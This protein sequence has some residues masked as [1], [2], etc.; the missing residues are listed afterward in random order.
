MRSDFRLTCSLPEIHGPGSV[1]RLVR[2]YS[3]RDGTEPRVWFC[4]D[5]SPFSSGQTPFQGKVLVIV[6]ILGIVLFLL[7]RLCDLDLEG[8]VAKRLTDA[9]SPRT[10][11]WW[12]IINPAY[13]QK[14][15]RPEL[16]SGGT[17]NHS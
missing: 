2:R 12:K 7:I 17:D 3:Q 13:S 10:T 9:Y 16:L 4:R 11:R 5:G 8:L 14:K 15:G 6:A 1:R